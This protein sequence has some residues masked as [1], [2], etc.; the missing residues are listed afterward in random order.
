VLL[1]GAQVL[2]DGEDLDVVLAQHPNASTISSWVSPRPT[3]RPDFVTVVA[4][5]ALGI[6]QDA[7]RAL[8]ARAAARD[9]VQARATSTLWL[10]T[11][12]ARR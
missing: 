4:A 2:A 7:Q 3:M 5:H 8:P 11:P 10:K 9:G 1:G 12:G 6:A